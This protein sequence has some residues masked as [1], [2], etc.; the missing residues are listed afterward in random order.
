MSKFDEILNSWTT[1]DQFLNDNII[2]NIDFINKKIREL[3]KYNEQI[4]GVSADFQNNVYTRLEQAVGLTAGADFDKFKVYNLKR[5]NV[6]DDGTV[7]AYYG[8]PDFK[9]DGSN[10]QV[11]VEIPKV[12]YKMTPTK[13]DTN[14][15]GYHI[16][17][18]N[19]YVSN[20]QSHGFKLHP[21][22]IRPDKSERDFVYVG[23]YDG[24]LY[25]VSASAYLLEDEQV[26]D[27]TSDKLSSI[28]DA[29]PVSGI[30]QNLTRANSDKLATNRGAGWNCETIQITSLIQLLFIIEY[31]G[32]N[33]QTL[34]GDGVIGISDNSSYNC[35]SYT[36]STSSLGNTSGKASLTKGYNGTNYTAANQVAV[37]YRGIE[38]PWGN[39]W[40]FITGMNIYG[41]GSQQGGVPYICNNTTF[42]E[43]TTSGYTSAGFSVTASNG[44]I[45]AFGYGNADYDW[46]FIS[47]ETSGDSTKP[48]GDY[49]YITSNLNGYRVARLG[50]SWYNGSNAGGFCWSLDYGSSSRARGIGARLCFNP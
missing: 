29:R 44:Y 5:C 18:A 15:V 40:K 41:N 34:L 24:S 19:Y 35:A 32:F 46:L 28:A 31:A 1:A 10:G 3:E 25:D 48:V 33:T 30:T 12:Y 23:A 8:D 47:S 6:S 7:T 43:E 9:E 27:F 16:R 22:F 13:L 39:I 2:S 49:T 14:T 26:A 37:S 17:S 42:T 50:S 45:S 21:A 4:V 20:I 38:N 36:G 11:M